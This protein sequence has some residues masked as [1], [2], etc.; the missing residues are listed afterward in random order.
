MAEAKPVDEKREEFRQ[1]LERGGVMDALTRA[2]V[3]LYEENDKPPDPVDYVRKALGDLRPTVGEMEQAREQV[4]ESVA[5][6][7]NLREE[8]DLL[9]GKLAELEPENE[10][11]A[12]PRPGDDLEE[13]APAEGD[14]AEAPPAEEHHAEETEAAALE[15]TEE[16][17]A[18][19]AE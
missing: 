3:A 8:N 18:A 2:L 9:R 7:H 16:V 15:V 1:Y 10:I 5:A 19:P 6:L 11:L 14:E 12:Q 13:A 17:V 4:Q